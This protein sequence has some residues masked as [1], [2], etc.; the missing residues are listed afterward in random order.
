[1][2]NFAR[3]LIKNSLSAGDPHSQQWRSGRAADGGTMVGCQP[4]ALVSLDARQ[5]SFQ[6]SDRFKHFFAL[7]KTHD[8]FVHGKTLV[9]EAQPAGASGSKKN[10]GR[11][12]SYPSSG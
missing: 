4:L 8:N 6:V 3:N 5:G 9:G 1:M 12:V 11:P 2:T 7:T 10:L